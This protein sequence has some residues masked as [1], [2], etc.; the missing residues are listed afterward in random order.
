MGRIVSGEVRRAGTSSGGTTLERCMLGVPI[1]RQSVLI[2]GRAGCGE[3]TATDVH[4]PRW[5]HILHQQR[6]R[7]RPTAGLAYEK[8]NFDNLIAHSSTIE[9]LDA[10]AE[11]GRN[12][13]GSTSGCEP[14]KIS[15]INN[16]GEDAKTSGAG[17]VFEGMGQ[18]M[19]FGSPRC[20]KLAGTLASTCGASCGYRNAAS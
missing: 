2:L 9:L 11:R 12:Q 3:G 18:D 10:C 8:P 20:S 7:L 16:S 6:Y 15:T 4:E 1:G 13:N 14:A 19:C 5:V 17:Q